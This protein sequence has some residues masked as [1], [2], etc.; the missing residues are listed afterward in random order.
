MISIN[1]AYSHRIGKKSLRVMR[2]DGSPVL[3]GD[4]VVRHEKHKVL[5]G[6]SAFESVRLINNELEGPEKE[7][8]SVHV[9]KIKE[10]FN[11]VTMPFYWGRF[12][13]RRGKPDTE[14]IMKTARYWNE[15]GMAVK[16]HPLCW[17]TVC[18]PWLLDMTDEEILQ[19]QIARIERDVA[20]FAG[21]IGMWDVINEVVIMP[22]F[23]KY[24]N[25]ITRI[26][27]SEGRIG[28][29]KKVFEASK[30][31][32]PEAVLLINDFDMSVSYDILLEGLLEVGIPIDAIGLQSHMHQGY[33]GTE[34]TEEILERFSR[35]GLP[36]HFTEI[37][38]VSGEI[39]P[40]HIEDLN[41]FIVDEWP[42]T[43]EGEE[44]QA[45]EASAFY[46]LLFKCPLVEAVTYWNFTDG[47]WL[48]APA[49]L[50]TKDARVKPAYEAL[51]SLIKG[52]WMTPEQ[53]LTVGTD[54]YIEVTGFK[55]E[56][57][58]E[59]DGGEM[60]FVID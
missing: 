42:S 54:G 57:T 29:V 12:E 51:H 47:A 43:A 55:G 2:G 34:K 7:H 23:N 11:F 38:M 56:Y 44:R 26:C 27:K 16:G 13:P 48:N 37:N 5:F 25:G 45:A 17:H 58:A 10:L 14:R 33:W 41:D 36:L 21:V 53:R 59:F 19:T 39:M 3:N 28:L 46:K 40:R 60:R 4:V 1:N 30:R 18:A 52:E 24:D 6:C 31:T 20:D 49:G 22:V 15:Q 50:M 32:N 9:Q 8:A 35:F